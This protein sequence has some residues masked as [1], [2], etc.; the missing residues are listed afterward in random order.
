MDIQHQGRQAGAFVV[1]FAVVLTMFLIFSFGVIE[2]ARAM[3]LFSTLQ[4]VT[5]RAAN[6]ASKTDF[7][8]PRAMDAVRQKAVLRTSPGLL[9]LGEPITDAHIRIDYLSL[10][11]GAG[12]GAQLT[13]I[14]A[15]ALPACPATNRIMCMA[16]PRDARCIRLVRV[17]VCEPGDANVCNAVQNSALT[18]FI[19]LPLTLPV[20]T[21]IVAAETLGFRPGMQTCP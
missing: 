5:R 20:A 2:V 12:G 7:S 1:E 16:N 10:P 3:Y 11:P 19:A 8:D 15:A 21:T 9:P 17:R 18:G 14:A 13:P 4:D 6:L